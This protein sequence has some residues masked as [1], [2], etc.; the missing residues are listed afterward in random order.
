MTHFAQ[1]EQKM[2]ELVLYV[3]LR[4]QQDERFGKVKLNKLVYFSDFF[5]YG[6]LGR[7]ITGLE[8]QALARGPVPRRMAPLIAELQSEGALA[9]QV[10]TYF[11]RRQQRPIAL[12][13]PDLSTFTAAE[14][15]LVDELIGRFWGLNATE[16]SDLTHELDGWKL[17]SEGEV[18]P[19]FTAFGVSNDIPPAAMAYATELAAMLQG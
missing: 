7:P 15:A 9:I 17:A 8:Y 19:Y 14:I 2:K 12:R 10:V 3:A 16:M 11:N 13:D 18:I 5:A 1:D 4:C 6:K